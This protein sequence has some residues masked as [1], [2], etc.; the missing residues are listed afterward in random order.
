MAQQPFARLANEEVYPTVYLDTPV[1][2]CGLDLLFVWPYHQGPPRRD[3]ATAFATMHEDW[4]INRDSMLRRLPP[5]TEVWVPSLR[6]DTLAVLVF[7]WSQQQ[8]KSPAFLRPRA[9]SR[10]Y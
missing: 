7:R 2:F 10:F 6:G 4:N 9:G 3:V 8:P 5:P 1:G